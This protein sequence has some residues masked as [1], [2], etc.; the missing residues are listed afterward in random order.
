[1]LQC[2]GL[3]QPEFNPFFHPNSPQFFF[4]LKKKEFQHFK[5]SYFNHYFTI[6]FI[7]SI[8][9][10]NFVYLQS[11]PIIVIREK[12]TIIQLSSKHEFKYNFNSINH[13]NIFFFCF[14]ICTLNNNSILIY[15]IE[16]LNIP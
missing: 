7:T 9:L 1:L 12:N 11:L 4:F 15:K 10:H 2:S 3:I 13:P 14:K 6:I 5:A 8:I 16:H